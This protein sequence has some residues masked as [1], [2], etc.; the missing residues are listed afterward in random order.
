M[1][2]KP[3]QKRAKITV[4]AIIEAGFESLKRH[5]LETTTTR[6]IADIAG[7]GV[8]SVYEYFNNKE[9]IYRAMVQ[10]FIED[11]LR[12]LQANTAELLELS[13]KELTKTLIYRYRDL[14]QKNN[15][16]YLQLLRYQGMFDMQDHAKQIESLFIDLAM[17]YIAKHPEL[18]KLSH[19]RT[20]AYFFNNATV[21]SVV[22]LLSENNSSI[23][24]DELVEVIA[25]IV[26]NHI[27][28]EIQKTS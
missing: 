16:R 18:L 6:S 12:V 11:S 9:D 13:I 27:T 8:G 2:R 25:N 5:G 1:A 20:T 23:D 14:F 21:S 28:V 7:V 26:F 4:E 15:Q 17:Q 24:F 3:K 10:V 22:R 19:I